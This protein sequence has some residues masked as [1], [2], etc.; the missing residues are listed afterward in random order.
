MITQMCIFAEEK[1]FEGLLGG[2]SYPVQ[3][4]QKTN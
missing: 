3:L 2:A 1:V 4:F